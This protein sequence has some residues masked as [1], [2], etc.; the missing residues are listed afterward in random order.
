MSK[1]PRTEKARRKL[2]REKASWEACAIKMIELAR[3]LET[4]LNEMTNF[5]T[6]VDMEREALR[7]ANKKIKEELNQARTMI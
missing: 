3:T 6:A 2:K 1:T 5:A 4:E 7:F